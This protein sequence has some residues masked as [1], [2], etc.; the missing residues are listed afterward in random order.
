MSDF[1]TVL[2]YFC[3]AT[4]IAKIFLYGLFRSLYYL[5]VV[6]CAVIGSMKNINHWLNILLHI[7]KN[8]F[9]FYVTEN[10]EEYI[11]N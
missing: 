11:G 9:K 6:L 3:G 5:Q 7:Y 2:R 10:I 1:Y 4:C 8:L